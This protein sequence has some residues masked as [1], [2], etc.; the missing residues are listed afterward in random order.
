MTHTFRGRMACTL[1]RLLMIA[2]GALAVGLF[3]AS[4]LRAQQPLETETARLPVRRHLSVDAAYEFQTSAQGTE[5]ALPIALEYGLT[6][7]LALLV[8]PV[9][10]TAIVPHPG[11]RAIGLGDV[12]VTAEY[13]VADEGLFTPAIA[14]AAEE[15]IPTAAKR[16]IGAGRAD[17]TPFLIAS[18]AFG[19]YEVHANV[20]YSFMG[21]P[22]GLQVQNTLNLA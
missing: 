20:G 9:F 6:S 8:E 4:S 13:L 5:H 19:N 17:F 1:A 14:L 11:M 7:R 16:A 18:K 3:A 22:A 21:K 15:K 10:F 12:E 2:P